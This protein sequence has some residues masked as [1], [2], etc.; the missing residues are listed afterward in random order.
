MFL[1][2]HQAGF[3]WLGVALRRRVWLAG[4]GLGLQ[5]IRY[6]G[7]AGLRFGLPPDHLVK[8]RFDVGS[9]RDQ[10]GIFFAFNDAF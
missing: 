2:S 5:D 9:S 8:L 10:W 6:T 4:D 3:R 7:G 1:H